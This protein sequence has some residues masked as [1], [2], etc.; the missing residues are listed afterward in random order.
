MLRRLRSLRS[1]VGKLESQESQ[2]CKFLSESKS[3]G[4]RRLMTQL[5]YPCPSSKTASQNDQI[6]PH[7]AFFFYLGPQ[8]IG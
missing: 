8:W 7:S 6:I 3:K 2:W 5:E 4:R 1:P